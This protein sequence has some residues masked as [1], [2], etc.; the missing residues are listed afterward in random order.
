MSD[1][2][3]RVHISGRR[4]IAKRLVQALTGTLESL[5]LPISQ[6]VRQ[7]PRAIDYAVDGCKRCLCKITQ[8]IG[9]LLELSSTSPKKGIKSSTPERQ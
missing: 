4:R 2:P 8:L 1:Y 3:T 7:V 6:K 9:E 5:I